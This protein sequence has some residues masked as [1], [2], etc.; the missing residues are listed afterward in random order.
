MLVIC[1]IA[2]FLTQLTGKLSTDEANDSG[3]FL[4]IRAYILAAMPCAHAFL[5]YPLT[6]WLAKL[7]YMHAVLGPK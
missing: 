2:V 4:T 6:L 5:W 1:I 7:V 3:F